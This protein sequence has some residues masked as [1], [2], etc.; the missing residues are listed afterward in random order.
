VFPEPPFPA[1]EPP[2]PEPPALPFCAD[3]PEGA[4][5]A[6]PPPPAEVMVVNPE[7]AIEE[8]LPLEP[9]PPA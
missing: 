9:I 1:D 7:P 6:P 4:S 2:P 5:D 3:G 8:L